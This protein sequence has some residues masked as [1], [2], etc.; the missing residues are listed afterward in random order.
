MR[1]FY[2]LIFL[3]GALEAVGQQL[4]LVKGEDLIHRFCPGDEITLKVKGETR[5]RRSYVNNVFPNAVK[6]HRDTIPLHRIERVYIKRSRFYNRIGQRLII[7]GA[8]LFLVDQVNTVAVQ[9]KGFSLDPTVSRT[10]IA[11]V[12]VGLPLALIRPRSQKI[13]RRYRL[14]AIDERSIFYLDKRR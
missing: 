10:A 12:G 4:I 6:L 14:M 7:F 9:G 2:A 3:L 1:I 13:N 11:A 5:V 8:G